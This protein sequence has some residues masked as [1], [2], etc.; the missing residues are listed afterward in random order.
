MTEAS[1]EKEGGA[2]RMGTDLV[3]GGMV[4][5]RGAANITHQFFAWR[6]GGWDGGFLAHLHSPWGYDEPEL[7]RYSNRQFRPIGA[8]AR[9]LGTSRGFTQSC[10]PSR[11]VIS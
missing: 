7:L 5:A 4:L 11:I 3:L 8:D 2:H 10:P 1:P 6:T 9:Q